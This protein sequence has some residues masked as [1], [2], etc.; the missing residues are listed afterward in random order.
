[1]TLG[2]KRFSGCAV[3]VI[4]I[5]LS[6]MPTQAQDIGQGP[7]AEGEAAPQ[8]QIV[9]IARIESPGDLGYSV[10]IGYRRSILHATSG[11]MFYSRANERARA[12]LHETLAAQFDRS[13]VE[14]FAQRSLAMTQGDYVERA[15]DFVKGV[16]DLV[17][18]I[19]GSDGVIATLIT[20]FIE[21]APMACTKNE[22]TTLLVRTAAVISDQMGAVS[23]A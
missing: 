8:D 17:A 5:S 2:A 19:M 14:A 1:M 16:T 22:A 12:H 18:P 10:R 11:L 13:E 21:Q 15:S 23:Q 9:V 20:P 3:A 4:A 7:A 6:T